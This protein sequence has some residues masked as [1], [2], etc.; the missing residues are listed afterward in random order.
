MGHGLPLSESEFND[1]IHTLDD[2]IRRIE[3]LANDIIDR[4]NDGLRFLG[5]LAQGALDL[6]RRFGELVTK[7]FSEVGKFFT[8]WGVPWTLYSHGQTWTQQVGGPVHELVSKVDAGQLVTD[9]YWTGTAA[10]AYNGLLPLQVKALAAI[11]AATDDLDDALW[12]VAG[13]VIAFWLA[14]AAVLAP[15]IV[16]LIAAAAAALGVVTAPAAA[17]AA[18]ASTAKAIA[19]T[20]AVVTMSI[21]YL[22]TLWTQMR[23]LDQRLHNSD[24][25]PDGHWPTLV[26]DISNGRVHDGGKT[27]D[28][29]IKS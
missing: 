27:L 29:N 13:G 24:G 11:K 7:F 1:L 2:G 28:W 21:T 18:G 4:V 6:L 12:K 17:A 19:L 3:K 16:E 23:D 8:R 26:S 9:D 15:Y 25:L 14:I 20:T 22:T 5:P 10:T